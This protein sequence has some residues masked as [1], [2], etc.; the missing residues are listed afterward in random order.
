MKEYQ[1]GNILIHK[2]DEQTRHKLKIDGMENPY[3][4]TGYASENKAFESAKE[5][6]KTYPFNEFMLGTAVLYPIGNGAM[7]QTKWYRTY[8]IGKSIL[9]TDPHLDGFVKYTDIK[10][11]EDAINVNNTNTFILDT[12][13]NQIWPPE[14]QHTK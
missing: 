10:G 12:A 2:G 4:F 5:Q 9:N 1:N 6:F 7:T 14:P 3:M 13:F 11:K 8:K